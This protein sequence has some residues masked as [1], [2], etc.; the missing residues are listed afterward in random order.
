VREEGEGVVVAGGA[1]EYTLAGEGRGGDGRGA[2]GAGGGSETLGSILGGRGYTIGGGLPTE[3]QQQQ[4]MAYMR[5][6][7]KDEDDAL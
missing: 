2:G 1:G 7:E 5:S 4:H 3:L 6:L